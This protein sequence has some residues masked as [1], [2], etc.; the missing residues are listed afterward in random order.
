M[1]E[2]VGGAPRLPAVSRPLRQ[3]RDQLFGLPGMLVATS[4]GV[5]VAVLVTV[6]ALRPVPALGTLLIL[7][8]AAL[9]ALRPTWALALLLFVLPFHIVLYQALTNRLHLDLSFLT[10]WKDV[11]LGLLLVRGVAAQVQRD[12]IRL[13]TSPVIVATTC[14]VFVLGLLALASPNLTLAGYGLTHIAEG[15]LVLLAIAALAPSRRWALAALGAILLAAAINAFAAL[16][17]QRFQLDFITWYG[18]VPPVKGTNTA[19]YTSADGSYR[20][21]GFMHSP[22]LLAFYLGVTTCLALGVALGARGRTRLPAMLVTGLCAAAL[23]VTFTRSGYLGAAAGVIVVVAL[24][25][26]IR[27]LRLGLGAMLVVVVG[28]LLLAQL[29]GATSILTREDDQTHQLALQRDLDLIAAQPLGFGLGT[30]DAV[31]QRFGGGDAIG[32][33]ENTYLA[34]AL[35]GG[36]GE[37]VAYLVAVFVL[38]MTLRRARLRALAE[39]DNL[40]LGMTAGALGALAAY[41]VASLFLGI[42]EI[43]VEVPLWAGAGLALC[44]AREFLPFVDATQ[45]VQA[46][47]ARSRR[48]RASGL[49]APS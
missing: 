41:S 43:F 42:Q 38:V 35:E 36:V 4:A 17:E 23:A 14:Y 5:V 34:K 13:P 21:G 18:G 10:L 20:S 8:L 30:V 9:V 12:G 33:S 24:G 15:P 7:C 19:F 1:S 47:A 49:T 26:P 39:G 25:T 16:I 44:V 32:V 31:G 37:L 29:A 46:A 11:L 40:A 45:Q 3:P 22:L 48:R 28:G 6:A 2:P 27:R